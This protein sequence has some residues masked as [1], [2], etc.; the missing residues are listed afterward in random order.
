V[1]D[2]A[3]LVG[4]DLGTRFQIGNAGLNIGGE[5][6]GGGRGEDAGGLGSAAIVGA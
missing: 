3:D 6:G 2:E 1:T 4:I 5:I